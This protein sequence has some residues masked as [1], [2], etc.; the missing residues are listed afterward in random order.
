MDK[1]KLYEM[2]VTN[3]FFNLTNE[4]K[5]I[6]LHSCVLKFQKVSRITSGYWH[7]VF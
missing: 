2:K 3:D 6:T 7:C 4:H 5:Q 1:R